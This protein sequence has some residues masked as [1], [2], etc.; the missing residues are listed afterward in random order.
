MIKKNRENKM[1][2][3]QIRTAND[4]TKR[5]KTPAILLLAITILSATALAADAC[6]LQVRSVEYAASSNRLVATIYNQAPVAVSGPIL[7]YFYDNGQKIGEVNYN[8]DIPRYSIV[9]VY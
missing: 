2:T 4:I 8:E 3:N 1:A 5:M 7:V 6:D 9:S